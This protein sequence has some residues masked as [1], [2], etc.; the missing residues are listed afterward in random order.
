MN[1]PS[2]SRQLAIFTITIV[3]ASINTLLVGVR[4]YHQFLIKQFH[5]DKP[6]ESHQAMQYIANKILR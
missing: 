4:L 5:W 3:F 1:S 2:D 6:L